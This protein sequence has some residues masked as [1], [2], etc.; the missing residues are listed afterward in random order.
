[1]PDLDRD[2]VDHIA[3]QIMTAIVAH[4]RE[5]PASPDRVFEALNALAFAAATVI[6]GTGDRDGRR[7][8]RGF[9][10]K[11]VIQNVSELVRQPPERVH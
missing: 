5:G 3:Q 10:D 11:A 1:M 9:F 7:D 6:V 8:A 2:R 4:Y